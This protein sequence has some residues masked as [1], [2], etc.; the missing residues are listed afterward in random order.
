MSAWIESRIVVA[1]GTG[2]IGR[3]IAGRLGEITDDL[4][5]VGR[6]R[7]KFDTLFPSAGIIFSD[8]DGYDGDAD[9]FINCIGAPFFSR[10]HEFD[11]ECMDMSYLSN[12]RIPAILIR[13][14][15]ESMRKK[16]RGWIININYR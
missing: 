8:I 16:G 3:C 12:F 10:S 13:K 9:I 7:E 5:I 6:D 11:E 4:V 14:T 2:E 15:V 1:G